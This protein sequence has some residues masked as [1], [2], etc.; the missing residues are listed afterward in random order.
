MILQGICLRPIPAGMTR[1]SL[2]SLWDDRPMRRIFPLRHRALC[3]CRIILT[4]FWSSSVFHPHTFSCPA[5]NF[6]TNKRWLSKAS[7]HR[8]PLRCCCGRNCVFFCN[9]AIRLTPINTEQGKNGWKVVYKKNDSQGSKG[10]GIL[11]SPYVKGPDL[12]WHSSAAQ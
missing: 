11:S 2:T 5:S 9:T 4:F 1:A 7:S 10:W 3:S 12:T 6:Q 8:M